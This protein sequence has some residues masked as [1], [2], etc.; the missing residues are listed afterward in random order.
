MVLELRELSYMENIEALN[1]PPLDEGRLRS[2]Q[3]ISFK[4]LKQIDNVDI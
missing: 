2:N 4:F 1:L 3:I